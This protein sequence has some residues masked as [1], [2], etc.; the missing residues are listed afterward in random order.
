M[1]D[2][3]GADVLLID[4]TMISY[5]IAGFPSLTIPIGYGPDGQ[6]FGLR[7]VAR[8]LGEP[9]LIAVG[10]AIEQ[11]ANARIAPDLDTVLESFAGLN[12]AVPSV[13]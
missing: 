8:Y 5:P 13:E 10:Y 11:A 3:A 6:P 9:A 1:L 12:M 2:G 4:D 7:F